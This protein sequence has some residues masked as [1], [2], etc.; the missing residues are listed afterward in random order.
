MEQFGGWETS[1]PKKFFDNLFTWEVPTISWDGWGSQPFHPW[2]L[3]W[4][5]VMEVWKIIFLS[6]WVICRFHVNLPGCYKP[7]INHLERGP[8][9]LTWSHTLRGVY[10]LE[11]PTFWTQTWRFGSDNFS[12]FNWV[13]F[14]WTSRS[15]SGVNSIRFFWSIFW[16]IFFPKIFHRSWGRDMFWVKTTSEYFGIWNPKDCEMCLKFFFVT[17]SCC[18]FVFGSLIKLRWV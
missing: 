1:G 12:D 17:F 11:N 18:G 13:I 6:K 10:T 5:I 4:N 2:R 9:T 15:F 8:T 7:C 3:T 16:I 14:R